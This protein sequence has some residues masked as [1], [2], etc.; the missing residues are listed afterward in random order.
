MT[1]LVDVWVEKLTQGGDK[2]QVTEGEFIV[3][4]VDEKGVPRKVEYK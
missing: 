1:F 3:V 4:A 2:E